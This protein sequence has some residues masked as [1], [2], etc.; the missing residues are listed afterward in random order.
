LLIVNISPAVD[1]KSRWQIACRHQLAT[2]NNDG[3]QDVANPLTSLFVSELANFFD[4]ATMPLTKD[5]EHTALHGAATTI[6][7]ALAAILPEAERE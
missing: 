6:G 1:G 3:V 7:E 4:L 2:S 5:S